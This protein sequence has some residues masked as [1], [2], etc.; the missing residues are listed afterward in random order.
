LLQSTVFV[1]ELRRQVEFQDKLKQ[2]LDPSLVDGVIA[3]LGI[4][5]RELER[6][7]SKPHEPV[8]QSGAQCA[9]SLNRRSEADLVNLLMA[10]VTADGLT[11]NVELRRIR[12]YFQESLGYDGDNLLR[13]DAL[14]QK[15]QEDD[16]EPDTVSLARPFLSRP[17]DERL[18]IYSAC[19]DIAFADDELV[20]EE[21]ELLAILARLLQIDARQSAELQQSHGQASLHRQQSME[22]K[23]RGQFPVENTV[24]FESTEEYPDP[25]EESKQPNAVRPEVLK[26]TVELMAVQLAQKKGRCSLA[27][28][29][30]PSLWSGCADVNPPDI[31]DL[32]SEGPLFNALP[33]GEF[34]LARTLDQ[35][36][37]VEARL[38]SY[39]ISSNKPLSLRV[40]VRSNPNPDRALQLLSKY[41]RECEAFVSYNYGCGTWFGLAAWGRQGYEETV[42]QNLGEIRKQLKLGGKAS[43]NE[44]E[45]EI[46]KEVATAVKDRNLVELAS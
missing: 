46:L 37:Q 12:Q 29:E 24:R 44:F 28:A 45:L 11:K 16:V 30:W 7:Q 2:C 36:E 40:V 19:T 17:P 4:Q 35:R 15:A 8:R 9:L 10:V 1:E 31:A 14:V 21:Q 26:K 42:R 22:Q 33:A 38:L 32:L 43:L 23:L 5:I 20:E 27:D 25:T 13:I 18:I 6:G 3:L 34:E 41:V 39:L